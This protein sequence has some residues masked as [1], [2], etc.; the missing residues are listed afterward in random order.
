MANC[1]MYVFN[2]IHNAVFRALLWGF[3]GRI[4][5][6]RA[7]ETGAFGRLP[8]G[9]REKSAFPVFLRIIIPEFLL[10]KLFSLWFLFFL[11][12]LSLFSSLLFFRLHS[13]HF[14]YYVSLYFYDILPR[15][16]HPAG[17]RPP[18]RVDC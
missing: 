17:A 10:K 12:L 9:H 3:R 16:G 7:A 6:S 4:R 8:T 5:H 13:S 2:P 15:H 18:H 14:V 11:I 1:A